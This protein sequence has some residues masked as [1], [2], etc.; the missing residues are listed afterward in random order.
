MDYSASPQ[1]AEIDA[2]KALKYALSPAVVEARAAMKK[3]ARIGNTASTFV[4]YAIGIIALAYSWIRDWER[5]S[6]SVIFWTCLILVVGGFGATLLI[7]AV[8]RLS[9][10]RW[11]AK[12]ASKALRDDELAGVIA[13]TF[14]APEEMVQKAIHELITDRSGW[15][16]FTHNDEVFKIKLTKKWD[17]FF[18][19]NVRLLKVTRRPAVSVA[20]ELAR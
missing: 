16:K 3:A 13:H 14:N 7:I 11:A 5:E 17:D 18:E 20:A 8:V 10:L 4:P 6:L 1:T 12:R 9:L 15:A 19:E 2:P